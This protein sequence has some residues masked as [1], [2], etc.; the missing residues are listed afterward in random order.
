MCQTGLISRESPIAP[1]TGPARE[2]TRF[3]RTSLDPLLHLLQRNLAALTILKEK[4]PPEMGRNL[5][6]LTILKE[7]CPPE[8]GRNLAALTSR[9]EK[10]LREAEIN[11]AASRER[12][13]LEMEVPTEVGVLTELETVK[14]GTTEVAKVKHGGRDLE[15]AKDRK[16]ALTIREA[17]V[18]VADS[19]AS[20]KPRGEMTSKSLAIETRSQTRIFKEKPLEETGSP[21]LNRHKEALQRQVPYSKSYFKLC[22]NSEKI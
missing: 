18:E 7:K 4:C 2:A 5:A 9:R 21:L 16:T 22:C 12:H 17:Q 8:M 13:P 14:E 20:T 3:A 19:K 10:C 15:T 6:A 11:L 1:T